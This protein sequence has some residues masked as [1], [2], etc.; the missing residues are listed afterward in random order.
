MIAHAFRLT[1]GCDLKAELARIAQAHGFAAACM[2]SCVG[3]LSR[4]RL[5]MPGRAGEDDV[6]RTFDEPM[7]IVSLAGT[8]G[9]EGMHIHIALSRAD[10]SCV[11]GHL[12]GGC[13]VH[14]TAEL[15]IGELPGIAFRRP[16]DPA[17]GY[18]ELSVEALPAGGDAASQA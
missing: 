16:I 1:P 18:N 7:E 9:P 8:L 17:T 2:V 5:R 15:V 11:G 13:I 3:S 4:A 10:G 14:T 6:F 12:V